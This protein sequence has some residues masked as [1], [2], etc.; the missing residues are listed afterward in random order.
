MPIQVLELYDSR[1]LSAS[2]S[3]GQLTRRY[4]VFGTSDETEA[5]NALRD[6]ANCPVFYD[7]LVRTSI[8]LTPEGGGLW[9]G[10][11]EYGSDTL[12][13]TDVQDPGSGGDDGGDGGDAG[14]GGPDQPDPQ[15]PI[16]G[17][18]SF[19]TSGGTQHITQSKRTRSQSFVAP[20]AAAPDTKLGI[21]VRKDRVDGTDILVGKFEFAKT[22]R[23]SGI[24]R[25]YLLMLAEFTGTIN[26][27]KWDGWE[28]GE[29]L[30]LGA[31]GKYVG[32]GQNDKG[33]FEITYKF[34]AGRNRPEGV[35]I[36]PGLTVE[37]VD[38]WD[39]LWVGY[40]EE[41]D[42]AAGVPMQRPAFANVEILYN[43]NDFKRLRIGG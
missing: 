41:V 25:A 23:L 6:D 29:V 31:T 2:R 1:P 20:F 42:A 8:K 11:V 13:S 35:Q 17:E 39:Y 10:E 22:R 40:L 7:G 9:K 15:A 36:A 34:A 4:A 37:R 27:A 24:N 18:Y 14:N 28:E 5:Y 33:E 21:G 32:T 3:G 38:A 43:F 26:D 16:G 30:F 12:A 19:D